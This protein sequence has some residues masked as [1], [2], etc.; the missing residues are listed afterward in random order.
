MTLVAN[1]EVHSLKVRAVLGS[2]TIGSVA[3]SPV[4][5]ALLPIAQRFAGRPGRV[6]N[7][8]IKPRPGADA[9]VAGELRALARGRIDVTPADNELRLLSQAAQPNASPPPCSLSSAR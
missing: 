7:V 4:A 3:A 2:Q 6:T 9:L 5:I 1:G 8:L